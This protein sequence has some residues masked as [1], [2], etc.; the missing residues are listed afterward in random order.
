MGGWGSSL[1]LKAY[2]FDDIDVFFSRPDSCSGQFCSGQARPKI[3]KWPFF[4]RKWR[5][6]SK[7]GRFLGK[8]GRI[9]QKL[10]DI[11][12]SSNKMAVYRAKMGVFGQKWP[13]FGKNGHFQRYTHP[14]WDASKNRER[15]KK[16]HQ[17]QKS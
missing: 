11:D 7:N 4:R 3:K 9:L 5:V 6:L 8:N 14:S 17:E 1:V 10:T 13:F 12:R 16:I 15:V 2:R